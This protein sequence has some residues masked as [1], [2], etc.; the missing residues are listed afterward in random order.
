MLLN[1]KLEKLNRLSFGNLFLIKVTTIAGQQQTERLIF[2]MDVVHSFLYYEKKS[3]ISFYFN[4]SGDLLQVT[5]KDTI[6]TIYRKLRV[7]YCDRI[8]D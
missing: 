3:I 4:V 7:N 8:K 2:Q 5:E 6:K 1:D